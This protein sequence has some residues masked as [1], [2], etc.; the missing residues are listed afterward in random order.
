MNN[1]PEWRNYEYDEP[2]IETIRRAQK[3]CEE[4]DRKQQQEER[5]KEW[6]EMTDKRKWNE[7]D[8]S[9]R[10]NRGKTESYNIHTGKVLFTYPN[11]EQFTVTEAWQDIRDEFRGN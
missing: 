5:K 2:L 10:F 3:S 1:R 6:E 11:C 8:F 9:V 4:R 7:N